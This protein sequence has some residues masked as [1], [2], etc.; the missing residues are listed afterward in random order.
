MKKVS[1]LT[2]PWPTPMAQ[3]FGREAPLIV[4]IGFGNGEY[5][6]YLA[7]Q[8]PSANVLGIEIANQCLEKAETLIDKTGIANVRLIHSRAETALHHLLQPAS[9]QEIHINYPDPWF[10]KRHSGRRLIQ[11]DT[12]DVIAN[13]LCHGGWFYLATD[14][15]AYAEMSH[16]LL[17]ETPSLTNVLP[18]PW[19]HHLPNRYQTKYER[20]GLREGRPGHYFV[21]QRNDHPAPNIPVYQE[22]DMPHFVA[23]LSATLPDIL[24][25]FQALSISHGEIHIT[26]PYAYISQGQN[27]LLFEVIIVEPTIEQH[28]AFILRYRDAE[29]DYV[30]RLANLGS[31]RPTEGVH[32]AAALIGSWLLSAPFGARVTASKVRGWPPA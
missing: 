7:A 6:L 21:Y 4:E 26:I 1:S 22:R 29:K 31:P 17:S 27:A 12:L 24:A 11:R 30:L 5:L 15:H 19:V 13:R 2:L 10:K 28:T 3:L 18:T 23:Q 9:I 8:N 20:K 16:A 25:R 32:Y 14:I